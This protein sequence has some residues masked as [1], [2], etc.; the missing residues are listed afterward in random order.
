M[1]L[2]ALRARVRDANFATHGVP[3]LVTVLDEDPVET[4]GIW[5]TA[6]TEDMPSLM[7]F[8]RRE[9]RRILALRRDEVPSVPKGTIIVGPESA[10]GEDRRWVVDGIDR[11]EA[12]HTRVI[13][14]LAVE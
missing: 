5:L 2:G 13:V 1:D 4:N 10:G 14:L 9:V 11:Q 12:D 3:V 8:Q 6:T 7:E